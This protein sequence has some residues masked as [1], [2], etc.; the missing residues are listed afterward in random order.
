MMTAVII[1]E[2]GNLNDSVTVPE[3]PEA[4]NNGNRL[5]LRKGEKINLNDLLQGIIILLVASE[6]FLYK[7]KQK[8]EQKLAL[9][10]AELAAAQEGGNV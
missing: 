3:I 2:E 10:Q 5:Y 4:A 6:R 1:I 7:F 9:E 8:H